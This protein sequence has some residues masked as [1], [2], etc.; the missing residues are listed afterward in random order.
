MATIN[1][2]QKDD[3]IL[4]IWNIFWYA[5]TWYNGSYILTGATD[6]TTG[7]HNS[8]SIYTQQGAGTYASSLCETSTDGGFTDWY[9]PSI[10]ELEEMYSIGG[11]I[12]TTD[13]YWSSTEIDLNNAWAFD[14]STG[15]R[16]SANKNVNTY[17]SIMARQE[18]TNIPIDYNR[19]S[20]LSKNAPILSG[21][22]DNADEDVYKMLG[23]VNGISKNSK[24]MSNE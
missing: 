2:S 4:Q 18:F 6:T 24:I 19:M 15:L 21:G 16:V 11:L 14:T 8:L 20:E 13:T 12:G 17:L 1:I 5:S 7:I 23:G 22:V 9:L 3:Y 10:E